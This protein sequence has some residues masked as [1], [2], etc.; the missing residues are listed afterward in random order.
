MHRLKTNLLI[1]ISLFLAVQLFA[2]AAK[3]TPTQQKFIQFILPKAETANQQISEQRQRMLNL[4]HDHQQGDKLS[5]GQ[6][7]WLLSLAD[8]YNVPSPNING[9][10]TW[11]LL[12]KR[13]DVIPP[14]L[15]IAQ[16]ANESAWGRSRFA[17]QGHNYYGLICHN[18][19]CGI[20]PKRRAPGK[21]FEV[22]RFASALQSIK[23]YMHTLNTNPYYQMLRQLRLKQR[24]KSMPLNPIALATGLQSYSELGHVYIKAIQGLIKRANLTQYDRTLT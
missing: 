21:D 1:F 3:L 15:A 13:V 4:Y 6:Q 5:H 17:K 24:E 16:A 7:Q 10:Q 22:R 12:R 9:Q 14:S 2:N 20:V 23:S 8:R 11:Y 19:G 18:P